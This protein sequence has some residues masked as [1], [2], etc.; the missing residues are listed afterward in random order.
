[1][2]PPWAQLG[3]IR[4]AT[5]PTVEGLASVYAEQFA[6]QP[7]IEG[8]PRLQATGSEL[9]TH[10]LTL[11]LSTFYGDRTPRAQIE[12]LR[13]AQMARAAMPLVMGTGE[14]LGRFVITKLSVTE[15]R[16]SASGELLAASVTVELLEYA[17]D[18]SAAPAAT[19]RGPAVRTNTAAPATRRKRSVR[20]ARANVPHAAV[21]VRV[22]TR[23][24]R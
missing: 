9:A 13:T 18:P 7:V 14:V 21:P 5:D 22:S 20:G 19:G 6:Q 10:T 23:S 12:Q 24:A 16:T 4:F 15:E 11:R 1:M 8:K 17:D 2:S 3:D